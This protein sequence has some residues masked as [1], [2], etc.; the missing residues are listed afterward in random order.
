VIVEALAAIY[1]LAARCDMCGDHV[2]TREHD[3]RVACR[4]RVC[5]RGACAA[6]LSPAMAW[7]DLSHAEVLRAANAARE[8]RLT[9]ERDA[10]ETST[11]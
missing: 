5:D 3:T 9:R 4:W 8:A 11:P 1:D 10:R 2:A 6:R 7:R